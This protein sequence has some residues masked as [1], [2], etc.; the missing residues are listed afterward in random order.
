M[1]EEV[2]NQPVQDQSQEPKTFIQRF[3]E[4]ESSAAQLTE[5]F[6]LH[7][8]I[9]QTLIQEVAGLRE[10]NVSLRNIMNAALKL[11]D[12]SKVINTA[13]VVA[14]YTETQAEM[15][16]KNIEDAVKSGALKVIEEVKSAEHIVAFASDEVLYGYSKVSEFV[17]EKVK[18]AMKSAK[19]G[20][21]IE[22]LKVLGVYEPQDL[23]KVQPEAPAET[24][25][26][27]SVSEE[28]EQKQ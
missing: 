16:K 14:K 12:E 20:D 11:G 2:T 15:F 8:N 6:K 19:V 22:G 23:S 9:F 17:E 3:Q 4:L 26:Q 28:N 24:Q 7:S 10:Q 25:E 27:P 21:V 18:E 1:S 5:I 13:N